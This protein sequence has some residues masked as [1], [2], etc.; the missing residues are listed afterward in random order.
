MVKIV[1]LGSKEVGAACFQYL[2]SHA[3]GLDIE[4]IG[5]L[6]NNR[7]LS[8]K[9]DNTATVAALAEKYQ[10]PILESQEDL[11]HIEKHIDL[12]LSVQYHEI[13]TAQT[14]DLAQK[15]AINLHMAPLPDYRGCNQFSFAI[16]DEAKEFGTTLHLMTPGIDDG[17]IIAEKRWPL[18]SETTVSDLYKKTLQESI[19]LFE[20]SL[21]SIIANDLNLTPQKH[22][23]QFRPSNFHLRSEISALKEI[24][25]AWSDE[26]IDRY[27]RATY[28]PPFDPPYAIKNGKK[29]PLSLNWKEELAC[30]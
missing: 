2:L 11:F 6:T 23:A 5:V 16:I 12:L 22:Y 18:D 9:N 7:K 13:L 30:V 26:K 28:F 24:D 4:V 20:N 14:L 10:I 15:A 1:F 8:A 3:K 25:L 27:V 21:E 17:H 29:I 19:E